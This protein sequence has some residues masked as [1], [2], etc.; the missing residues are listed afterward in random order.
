[1]KILTMLNGDKYECVHEFSD[2]RAI[3]NL[4]GAY[5]MV[6]HVTPDCWEFGPPATIEER[7]VLNAFVQKS[8]DEGTVVSVTDAQ[9]NTTRYVDAVQTKVES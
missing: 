4:D 5:V 8:I 1:M 2:R 3:I 9:G 7:P 6:D